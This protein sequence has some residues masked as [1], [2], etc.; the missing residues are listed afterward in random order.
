MSQFFEFAANHWVLVSAFIVLLG[1]VV[2]NEVSSRFRGFADV[3]PAHATQLVNHQD[4]LLLDVREDS[5]YRE[6]HIPNARHIPL[7]A[8]GNRLKELEKFKAKPIV[9]YCRSGQRSARACSVLRKHGFDPI[10]NLGGGIIAWQNANFPV[11]K[12]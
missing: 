6:G 10:Y 7:S 12:K 5:E 8:I 3:S 1:L 4:A 9:A 2:A 11:S